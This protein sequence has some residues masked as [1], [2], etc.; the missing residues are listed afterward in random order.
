MRSI[1]FKGIALLDVARLENPIIPPG[2]PG[3]LGDRGRLLVLEPVV[4]LEAGLSGP[5][6]LD[7]DLGADA[8]LV[9]DADV[10][11]A[12]QRGRQVLA[13]AADLEQVLAVGKLGVPRL[14]VAGIIVVQ[15]LFVA[16]VFLKLHLV[17][18]ESSLGDADLALARRLVDRGPD[19]HTGQGAN[20]A[21]SHAEEDIAGRDGRYVVVR[22]CDLPGYR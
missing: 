16:A 8:K 2:A 7:D 14:V 12:E 18:G 11:L 19:L 10:A 20:L 4:Q 22:V 6:D 5:G 9:R 15:G 21:R 1:S 17:A 13:K 3:V